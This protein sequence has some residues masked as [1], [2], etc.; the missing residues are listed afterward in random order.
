MRVVLLNTTF[1]SPYVGASY[2]VTGVPSPLRDDFTTAT[3][4]YFYLGLVVVCLISA[5]LVVVWVS[6][7]PFGRTLKSIRAGDEV[8][9][10]LGKDVRY[11]RI[12]SMAIGGAIAGAGGS[13]FAHFIGFIDP[14]YFLPLETFLVW[15]MVILCGSGNHL[16]APA[17]TFVIE[18]LYNATRFQI[19]RAHV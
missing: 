9:M 14:T 10:A 11:A 4:C 18:I 1:G 17:G 16:G 3:Y 13:L 2:G 5:Y 6:R 15:A 19:G 7:S 12:G 8:A